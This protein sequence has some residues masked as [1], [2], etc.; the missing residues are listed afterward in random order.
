MDTLLPGPATSGLGRSGVEAQAAVGETATPMADADA[1]ADARAF[2][3]AR[4]EPER[5]SADDES[6]AA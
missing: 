4:R 1:D 5:Q 2:T 3:S 6:H